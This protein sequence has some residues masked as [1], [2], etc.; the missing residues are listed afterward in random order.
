MRPMIL[1]PLALVF[2]LVL[3][4]CGRFRP[5]TD[6]SP[7]VSRITG[8]EA[9]NLLSKAAEAVENGHLSE[10]I[11]GY[12][13]IVTLSEMPGNGAIADSGRQAALPSRE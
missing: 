11:R 2:S 9:A 13:G 4:S 8:S 6:P 3:A 1:A 7:T 10:A 12:I 5:S